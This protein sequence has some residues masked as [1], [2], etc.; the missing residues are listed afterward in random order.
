[1][2]AETTSEAAMAIQR[3]QPLANDFLPTN[4][5]LVS[6]VTRVAIFVISLV[7]YYSGVRPTATA[8]TLSDVPKV[9]RVR[10]V[11]ARRDSKTSL[12]RPGRAQ[13]RRGTKHRR[14]NPDTQTAERCPSCGCSGCDPVRY[15]PRRAR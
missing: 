4:S 8:M 7:V 14:T 12:T 2:A 11:V 6:Y 1:M 5:T 13:R 10:K 9:S 15:V 3:P